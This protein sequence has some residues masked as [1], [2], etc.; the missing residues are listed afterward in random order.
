MCTHIYSTCELWLCAHDLV[1]Y[2][3]TQ[4]IVF[5][6][7]CTYNKYVYI[8]VHTYNLRAKYGYARTTWSVTYLHNVLYLHILHI[9]VHVIYMYIY[10]EY[11]Y[12]HVIYVRIV[13]MR[14]QPGLILMYTMS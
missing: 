9:C 2:V 11:V 8:C 7:M 6:C 13:A 3:S 10:K 14:A 1:C 5:T 4:C 12:T